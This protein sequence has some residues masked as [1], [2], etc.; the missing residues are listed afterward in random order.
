[1]VGPSNTTASYRENIQFWCNVQGGNP[2]WIID[3]QVYEEQ[4]ESNYKLSDQG[5]QFYR[6]RSATLLF[7]NL[8]LVINAKFERNLTKL[9]CGAED[10][11]ASD[12]Y[13]SSQ[14]AYLVIKGIMLDLFTIQN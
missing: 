4:T 11:N 5:I 2:F 8:I 1:M 13:I 9:I 14:P 7:V 12:T 6:G 3:G 10:L